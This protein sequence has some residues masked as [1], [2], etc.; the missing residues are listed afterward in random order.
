MNP[1]WIKSNLIHW[2][3]WGLSLL[4]NVKETRKHKVTTLA[5]LLDWILLTELN[6]IHK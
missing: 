3:A 6:R 2:K 4:I 5:K 1:T